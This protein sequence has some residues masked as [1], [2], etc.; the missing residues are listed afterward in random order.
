MA[1]QSS[2]TTDE[3][4]RAVEG[5]S[6]GANNQAEET[7]TASRN[8]EEMGNVI[9]QIVGS[10]DNLGQASKEM[11]DASDASTAIIHELSASNDKTTTAISKIGEQVY[12]TNNSVQEIQKAVEIITSIAEETNLLSLNASI[13]AAR[14][15]EH[16]RGFAVVASQIQK[17][18]EE[19]NHSALEITQIINGLLKESETTVQ[20][21]DEVNIIVKEQQLKL[22][23]T[24]DKFRLVAEGVN[25]TRQ[26]TEVIQKQTA[27]C[28][29]AR[30]KIIDVISNLSAISE[31]NAASTEETTAAMEEL[32]AM[33][34]L[35]AE[36][37][38]ELLTLASDLE[39]DMSFFQ[40]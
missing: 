23:Q 11:K 32:N 21:M 29:D 30:G 19:S 36:S 25:S 35:L 14:A 39:K 27:I 33:L 38:K 28:D 22:E 10:V 4:S 5:V 18:A 7:E 2:N 6:R 17:L 31:E 15:G 16:G 20:V 9:T 3:I 13:E 24:K 12:S 26:E 40:V 1:T 37:S 8:V 34:N